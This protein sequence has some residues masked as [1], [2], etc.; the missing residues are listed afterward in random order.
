MGKLPT[1][2]ELQQ[3]R[4][5]SSEFCVSLYLP[6]VITPLEPNPGKIQLKNMLREAERKLA[7]CEQS[8]A[9][10]DATLRP[11]WQLLDDS[12]FWMTYQVGTAVFMSRDMYRTYRIQDE[13]FEQRL[14]IGTSFDVEPLTMLRRANKT[15]YLLSLG[16]KNVR[17]FK[18]DHY[19]LE[20]VE[21]KDFPTDMLTALRIDEFPESIETHPTGKGGRDKGSEGFHGQYNPAQTDKLMLRKFFRMIDKRLRRVLEA[22]TT[23]LVLAGVKYLQPIYRQVNSYPHL[24]SEAINGNTEH[25]RSE[26]LRRK[27]WEIVQDHAP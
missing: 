22:N 2:K 17:L 4:T 21:V 8:S 6:A 20:P 7:E 1:K 13:D 24:V 16:H 26:V 9:E 11:G 15:F 18:G 10:I 12:E 5:H 25:E 14:H 27:A 3:L 19:H 23:P